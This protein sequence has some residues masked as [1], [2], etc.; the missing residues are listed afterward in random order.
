VSVLDRG[1][2]AVLGEAALMATDQ[3]TRIERDGEDL[4]VV[5]RAS[6]RRPT[7]RGSSE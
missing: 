4:V 1:D 7:S 6:T 2:R 3:L 5:T